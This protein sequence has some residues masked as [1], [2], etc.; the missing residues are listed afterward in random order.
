MKYKGPIF[1]HMWTSS[2]SSTI[3]WRRKN[4][5]FLIQLSWYL[6]QKSVD[7]R[8]EGG[9][10]NS[11]FYSINLHICLNASNMLWYCGFVIYIF[12]EM[13]SCLVPHVGVHWCDCG[14][15]QPLPPGF[16]QGVKIMPLHFS[17]G[18]RA[19]ET[20]SQKKKTMCIVYAT[21]YNVMFQYIVEWSN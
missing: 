14:S 6:C 9:F 11:Q 4:S 5:V 3:F 20:L 18:N 10:L 16:K 7:Y 12:F 13:E 1:F 15:L 2:C 21:G 19:R 8:C 17:L